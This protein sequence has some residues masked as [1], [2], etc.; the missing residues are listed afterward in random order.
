M[1][2]G[3]AEQIADVGEVSPVCIRGG[4]PA[5]YYSVCIELAQTRLEGLALVRVLIRGYD[6]ELVGVAVVGAGFDGS[7]ELAGGPAFLV[8]G[9]EVIGPLLLAGQ[10]EDGADMRPPQLST[11]VENW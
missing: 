1:A 9:P 10:A 7:A 8:S 5:V 3:G 11:R 4:V 6:P 2:P